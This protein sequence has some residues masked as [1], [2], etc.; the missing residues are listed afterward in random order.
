LPLRSHWAKF[1]QQYRLFFRYHTPSRVIVFAWVN[2]EQTRRAYEQA[3]D[4]Y[5]VFSNMLAS[6]HPPDDG[7]ALLAEAHAAATRWATLATR[8]LAGP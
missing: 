8:P 5:R 6:G 4:A 2:D 3:D 1:F 7:E